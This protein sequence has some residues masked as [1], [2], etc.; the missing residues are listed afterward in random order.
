MNIEDIFT[1]QKIGDGDD[2]ITV[3]YLTQ[4]TS[5]TSLSTAFEFKK[6]TSE[7]LVKGNATDTVDKRI[8][9]YIVDKIDSTVNLVLTTGNLKIGIEIARQ[10]IYNASKR[11]KGDTIIINPEN[12]RVNKLSIIFPDMEIIENE[13]VPVDTILVLASKNAYSTPVVYIYDDDNK[14][15][16]D[17]LN[18]EYI[19]KLVIIDVIGW[20]V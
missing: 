2:I 4:K 7:D 13:N 3:T 20:E 8:I 16:V 10:K 18:P 1:I 14:Y 12:Q 19:Q 9:D 11:F 17:I 15:K 5:E 6:Y